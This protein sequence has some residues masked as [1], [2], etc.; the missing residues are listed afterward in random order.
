MAHAEKSDH[1]AASISHRTRST[2]RS[3]PQVGAR[4]GAERQ[5]VLVLQRPGRVGLLERPAPLGR[6]AAGQDT[7]AHGERARPPFAQ[8]VDVRAAR[9]PQDVQAKRV[10]PRQQRALERHHGSRAGEAQQE[11]VGRRVLVAGRRPH[12]ERTAG[13]AGRELED[14]EQVRHEVAGD[15]QPLVAPRRGA[16]VARGAVAVED[17]DP[18]RL[19]D[20]AV[21][22][23]LSQPREVRLE[24]VV[25]GGV[26]RDA[27]LDG[28]ALERREVQRSGPDQRLLDEDVLAGPHEVLERVRLGAVGQA[29]HRGVVVRERDLLQRG[30][31]RARRDRIDRRDDALAGEPHA[32]LPLDAEAD[33]DQPHACGHA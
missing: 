8:A 11:V 28:Q 25:V 20:H 27:A 23:Q 21:A 31:G 15:P 1:V 6:L 33:D 2:Q 30:V 7:I 14:V 12:L 29:Q 17:R 24:A 22:Q 10:A 5:E 3:R 4:V 32:L 18:V 16:H 13:P 9:G 19:A 26:H